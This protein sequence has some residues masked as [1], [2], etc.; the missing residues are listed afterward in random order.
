MGKE[1]AQ[2]ADYVP[3]AATAALVPSDVLVAATSFRSLAPFVVAE[4]L[5]LTRPQSSK[6]APMEAAPKHAAAT[7]SAPV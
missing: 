4:R 7:R 3:P 5:L 1:K 2:T 6:Q